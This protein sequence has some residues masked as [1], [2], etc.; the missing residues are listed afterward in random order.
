MVTNDCIGNYMFLTDPNPYDENPVLL[1]S[2]D[3]CSEEGDFKVCE[4]LSTFEISFSSTFQQK[5][6]QQCIHVVI[7]QSCES[8]VQKLKEDRFSFDISCKDF[9]VG[10]SDHNFFYGTYFQTHF[11]FGHYQDTDVEDPKHTSYFFSEIPSY[12]RLL[13]Q[14]DGFKSQEHDRGEDIYE[15]SNVLRQYDYDLGSKDPFAALLE[16]YLSGSF[17][18][19]DFIISLA[20]DRKYDL[21]KEFLW[22]LLFFHYYFQISNGKGIF[23]DKKLL[24]WLLWKSAFT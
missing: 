8:D 17:Q 24:E 22:S 14:S 5:D 6:N 9:I 19:S 18:F 13:H 1:S 15:Q 21:L 23:L 2:C 12:N 4:D 16:S 20:F 10:E 3:H 7:D 11:S